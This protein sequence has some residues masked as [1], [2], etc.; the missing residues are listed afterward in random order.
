MRFWISRTCLAISFLMWR[1]LG[2]FIIDLLR[3]IRLVLHLGNI[4]LKSGW[5][6]GVFSYIR[7]VPYVGFGDCLSKAILEPNV[8]VTD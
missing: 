5:F 2:F 7:S 6:K 1:G 4:Y 8:I 3:S